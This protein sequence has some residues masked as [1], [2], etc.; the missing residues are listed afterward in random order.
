MGTLWY[1]VFAVYS[2]FG[3]FIQCLDCST[4]NVRYFAS[5]IVTQA[6]VHVP[7]KKNNVPVC[8]VSQQFI[9]QL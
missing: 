3:V 5:A 7:H 4:K 8:A 6:Q 2:L 9:M 1:I